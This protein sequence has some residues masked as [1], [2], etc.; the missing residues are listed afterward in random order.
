MGKIFKNFDFTLMFTPIF[1]AA[2]GIVM[3]YSASMVSAVVEGLESTY[4]LHRQLQ[5]FVLGLIAFIFCSII[6]YKAYQ[7]LIKIIIIGCILLLVGVLLFGDTANNATRAIDIGPIS[8]QPSEFVKLA[9]ILYLASVYSK[10]QAYINDFSKGVLP[11]L[12][13]TGFILA[14]ILL[15]PDIGTTAIIFLIAC[16]II[17]S[18]GIRFKH[19]AGLVL[20][21]VVLL[22]ILIPQMITGVRIARFTGAYQPFQNPDSNLIL[23]LDQAA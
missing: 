17:F 13:L 19:L 8:V 5:W 21:G 14:L 11:P 12:I 4:Y 23:Q 22:L 10:K 2:F 6:P 9:L 3:I 18:S 20:I 7:K 16:S 1:L 15:Q